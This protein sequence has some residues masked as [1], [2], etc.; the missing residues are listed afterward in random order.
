[1]TTPRAGV[2]GGVLQVGRLHPLL[3]E[4]LATTYAAAQLPDPAQARQ[5]LRESGEQIVAAVAGGGTTVGAELI[6]SLPKLGAIINVGVGYDRIDVEAARARGIG[7]SNTPDVLSDCV[8]DLA[9]GG[10]IDVVRGLS[11]ADRFVRR[12]DWAGGGRFPL[13][14]RLSGMRVGI[15][16]LGRIGRVIARRLE[17]F[18][19]RLSYHNRRRVP[20]VEYPYVDSPRALAA[21]CDA[22]IVAAAGGSGTRGLISAEVLAALGPR[23]YLVNVSR[24]S[25]VDESALVAALSGGHLGGAALDV[26]EHEPHVPPELMAL[27]NVVLLPHIGSATNETREAMARLA[28]RNLEQFLA[29]GTLTTPVVPPQ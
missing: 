20:D 10:L 1:M 17:G 28:L 8:A 18:D 27:D 19:A 3:E 6:A 5:V 12:G 2:T 24:G 16:G 14:T 13:T 26:F 4:E 11:A 9:V 29:D 21:A 23:G 25:V 22:V 7:V 15:V